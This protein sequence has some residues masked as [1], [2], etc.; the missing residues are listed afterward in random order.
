MAFKV[1]LDANFLLDLTLKREGFEKSSQV[2]QLALNGDL[3]LYSTPAV[4]HILSYFTSKAYSNQQT[5]E[6]ILTLMNDV[7]IIEGNHAS[8]LMALNSRIQDIEDAILYYTALKFNMDYFVSSDKQLKKSALPQLPIC[9]SD[10]LLA[11][12]NK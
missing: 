5:R 11:S 7:Q 3:N 1:F 12:V 8:T 6:I 2:F 9:T 10:E 4:L